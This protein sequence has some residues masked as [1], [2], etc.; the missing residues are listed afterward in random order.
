MTFSTLPLK[1]RRRSTGDQRKVEPIRTGGIALRMLPDIAHIIDEQRLHLAANDVV[2]LYT[3]GITEGK[4]HFGEMFSFDRL[5]QTLEKHGHR[6]NSEAIFD[7]I[8]E[9]Y[10]D[11]IEDA[12]QEDDVTMIVL[13]RMHQDEDI[14]RHNVKLMINADEENS[15]I[16]KWT[17]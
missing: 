3:D 7:A 8:T 4:N 15:E 12:D 10:S 16:E 1:W 6:K 2:L 14:S 5:V 9:E 13:R 17:W 11:F